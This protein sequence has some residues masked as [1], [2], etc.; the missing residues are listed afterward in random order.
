M[1]K[2]I[3]SVSDKTGIVDFAK[4]LVELDYE[5]YSTGGTK[6]ALDE[7]GV[8]VKSVSDLT[9]FDEIMDGRVKTLHPAVH[10]GIL[11]D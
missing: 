7:A 11:A 9:K 1:K 4:S 10:G 2:V 5:L 8:P 6:R 3:L